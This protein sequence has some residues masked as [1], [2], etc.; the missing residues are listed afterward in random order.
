MR[1][2]LAQAGPE[3]LSLAEIV[4]R[5]Q[6]QG[7]RDMTRSSKTPEASIGGALARDAVFWKTAPA[8]FALQTVVAFHRRF[9]PQYH[10]K[11]NRMQLSSSAYLIAQHYFGPSKQRAPILL[12]DD[13][14]D[15][16]IHFHLPDFAM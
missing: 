2:V 3:G 10:H 7:L 16:V 15:F 12:S 11:R 4:R 6:Q 9:C 1:Q 5:M 14:L 13:L 8:T